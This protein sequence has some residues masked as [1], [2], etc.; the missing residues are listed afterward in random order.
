MLMNWALVGFS[1]TDANSQ[2]VSLLLSPIVTRLSEPVVHSHF[3]ASSSPS[4][5]Q[6]YSLPSAN[7]SAQS[8]SNPLP[9]TFPSLP[10]HFSSFSSLVSYSPADLESI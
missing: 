7:S 2:L 1:V 9:T 10:L 4:F 6:P 8:P 3:I 5:S